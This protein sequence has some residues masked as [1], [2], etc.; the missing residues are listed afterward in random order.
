MELKKSITLD[1]SKICPNKQ[2]FYLH[3]NSKAKI[4]Y[5]KETVLLGDTLLYVKYG[6]NDI[7]K[8]KT[9]VK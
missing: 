1:P 8:D 7:V 6:E 5:E 3:K 4:D 2:K 9:A